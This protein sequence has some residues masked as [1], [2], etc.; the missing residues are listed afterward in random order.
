M[1]NIKQTSNTKKWGVRHTQMGLMF[2]CMSIGYALRTNMAVAIVA[3][4]D[5]QHANKDFSVFDWNEKT[6][7]VILSSFFW[8]YFVTQVF[9]G[10][11]GQKYG[12]KLLLAGA[13]GINGVMTLATPAVALHGG[14]VAVIASRVLQGMAQGFLYPSMN[15]LLS[16]WAPLSEKSRMF[17]FVFSGIQFGSIVILSI[18]GFLVESV[19][20][21]PSIFYV[22]GAITLMWVCVWCIYGCSSPSEHKT[23]SDAEK[24]YITSSLSNTACT[25]IPTPWRKICTSLPVWAILIAHLAENW[26]FWI[27]VMDMPSYVRF[28]LKFDIK[29]NGFL[30]A[31]P[32]LTTWM[33]MLVFSWI[34]DCISKKNCISNTVQR[35]MWNSISHWGGALALFSLYMFDTSVTGAM[36][37]LTA[38]LTLN[39]GVFTG[40]L[41]NHLDLAP[42]FAGTL[43][44][45]TNSLANLTAIAGSLLVG[46]IVTESSN[47]DQ[48]GIVFLISAIVF[49][50]GNLFYIVF[51]TAKTQSWN[52]TSENQKEE[53]TEED[54]AIL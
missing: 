33:T 26:G 3:M 34:S 32:Y 47:K 6:K 13:I 45:I 19:G 52:Y 8:G 1:E 11:M 41:S 28:V 37:L 42:N 31:L 44:G 38:A 43:M 25:K 29:S 4:T 48:W 22:S 36:F 23:I 9:A 10:H 15:V 17:S 46:F 5:K 18:S 54:N 21:W 53:K 49:F 35:K 50:A 2:C 40:F 39:S 51:G 7:S 27:L 20:G 24:E 14:Y 12:A 16:K 30:S